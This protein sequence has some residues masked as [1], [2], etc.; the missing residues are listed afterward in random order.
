MVQPADLRDAD[1][2]ASLGQLDGSRERGVVVQGH[3]RRNPCRCQPT[4]AAGLTISRASFQPAQHRDNQTQN[5]RSHGR[6]R[7]RR[8]DRRRIASCC[9]RAR[10]SAANAHRLT[11]KTRSQKQR[12]RRIGLMS[13]IVVAAC[14]IGHR[15]DWPHDPGGRRD[16]R[17]GAR[18]LAPAGNTSV[19]SSR[20]R[21]E[22]HAC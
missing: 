16:F 12:R 11:R 8:T 19:S 13:A 1:H 17:P 5:S 3:H 22:R 14:H 21:K 6:R 20:L 18:A 7:G 9:R 2:P 15:S 4:T 10:F